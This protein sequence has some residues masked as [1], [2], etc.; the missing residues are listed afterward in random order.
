VSSE[1]ETIGA[2]AADGA[3]RII[4]TVQQREYEARIGKL[5][6]LNPDGSVDTSFKASEVD[7]FEVQGIVPQ[8][9]GKILVSGVFTRFGGEL[10]GG[11]VRLMPDGTRDT[12]FN[13]PSTTVGPAK[14][15]VQADGKIVIAGGFRRINDTSFP[16]GVA[17]LNADGTLDSSFQPSG[18]TRIMTIRDPIIQEDGKIVLGGRFSVPASFASNPT[19]ATYFNLPLIRL[20]PDGSIDQSYG[21]FNPQALLFRVRSL[22]LS[23]GKIIVADSGIQATVFRFNAD[24]SLDS[25]FLKPVF[26]SNGRTN[27]PVPY[28]TAI[29]LIVAVQVDQRILVS[30][31]FTDV[32]GEAGSVN[33][34][35]YGVVRLNNDGTV[36]PTLTTPYKTAIKESPDSFA[37]LP[38]GTTLIGFS[39]ISQ[40]RD[41]AVPH[42]FSR[43]RPDGSLDAAFDPLSNVDVNGAFG[44]NFIAQGFRLLSDGKIFLF[45]IGGSAGSFRCGRLLPDGTEDKA[46]VPDPAI[47]NQFSTPEVLPQRDGKILISAFTA[48]EVV[49]GP[50]RRIALDGSLDTSFQLDSRITSQ[51][52]EREQGTGL[53]VRINATGRLLAVLP[54]GKLLFTYSGSIRRLNTDGSIDDSFTGAS[55]SARFS[56]SYPQIYDPQTNQVFQ[57]SVIEGE[58]VVDTAVQPDGRF[59]L[60]GPWLR[61]DG[62]PAPGIARFNADGSDDETFQVGSG[63]QWT[64]TAETRFDHWPKIEQI[65]LQDDG[66]LLVVGTFEAFNGVAAPGIVRLNSDGSVDTSFVAPAKRHK[67]VG[68]RAKLARQPDGSFLLSGPYS[69]P[70]ENSA[71]SLLRIVPSAVANISTRIAVGTGEN[72]LI[73]GFI[74]TGNAPKKVIIRAIGPSLQAGGQPV[75]GRL[76]DPVMQLR[77]QL[78][79]VL[80][81]NDDWRSNQEQEIIDSQVPPQNDRE[82]AVVATL[83][84]G[85]YT[86]IVSGKGDSIG[87]GLVEVYD[88]GTASFDPA[89]NATLANI[90]T[91]GFVETGDDI[92]I[93]GFIVTGAA[94]E[95]IVRAIGPSLTRTGVAG[96]L[97]D[98]TLEFRDGNGDLVAAN[99]DWRTGGQEQQIIDTTVPPSDDRESAVVA[100]LNPGAYTAIVRGKG[101]ATGVALVE[102]YVLQ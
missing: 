75:A 91:R 1:F 79:E 56:I 65:E 4:V 82:S 38:D 51:Q 102:V 86:A 72:V 47:L 61:Q 89:S 95:V 71:P 54:D 30:G 20:N 69:Y 27:T 29:P 78:G 62:T 40:T 80:M 58:A 19:G 42:N 53:I 92:M 70:G 85:A 63:P 74:V 101:S 17:R 23:A 3:G 52:V 11:I 24:G 12:S 45:G 88:L 64:E 55:V 25:S 99:D 18:F 15:A 41:T 76:Q 13:A 21:Y 26:R 73:G 57:P 84:P 9:E 60:A 22:A 7:A 31:I 67:S 6:R 16:H 28:G 59:I 98:T 87:I 66:K 77:N 37:R 100:A 97:Q 46:F 96:A 43:L 8:A 81:V 48:Q 35:R 14:P 93:G 49:N 33:G 83:N 50:P 10:G 39:S 2:A 36:D 5:I 44:P 68:G 94:S 32:D 90:S 34:S